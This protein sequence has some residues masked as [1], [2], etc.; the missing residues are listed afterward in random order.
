MVCAVG[1]VIIVALLERR[2]RHLRRD[3]AGRRVLCNASSLDAFDRPGAGKRLM[4][5]HGHW[6]VW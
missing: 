3:L 6:P 5:C 2:G 1:E 4:L